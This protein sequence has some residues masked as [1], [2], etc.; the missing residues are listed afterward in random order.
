MKQR[1]IT[2]LVLA[3]GAIA[4]FYTGGFVLKTIVAVITLIAVNE[5]LDVIAHDK[6]PNAVK[7]VCYLAALLMYYSDETSILVPSY[8]Y[9]LFML[10]M[11]I[12]VVLFEEMHID[13]AFL[14][15]SMMSLAVTGIR[16]MYTI[17]AQHGFANM[18]FLAVATFGCDTGAYFTGYFFGKHKLIERLSPKKTI[19]GSLGGI[20][21]GTLFAA[22]IGLI[23]DLGLP[24]YQVVLLALLLTITSQF[25]DLTFSAL[26][27]RYGIKDFSDLLPGH[28][29]VLDRVDSL[30]FNVVVYSVWFVFL[31]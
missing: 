26:K 20:C 19:E 17:T 31:V 16:G 25:G 28:G 23:A 14:L 1:I 6:F 15:I 12:C 9:L 24:F 11:F 22:G 10:T 30:I 4:A 18:M 8:M 7:I 29:G 3:A 21:L 13:D 2:G 5:I 27:R